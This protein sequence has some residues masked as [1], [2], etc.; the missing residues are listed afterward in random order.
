MDL[1]TRVITVLLAITTFGVTLYAEPEVTAQP[2]AEI[3]TSSPGRSR[4]NA[5]NPDISVNTLFLYRNG[6]RGNLATDANP[7]GF[8]LDEAELQFTADVDPY[9]RAVSLLAVAKDPAT[10][11]WKIEPEEAYGETLQVP[12]VTL[13]FGK[14]KAA[15]GK[16][17]TLHTHAFPFIDNQLINT[18][19]LGDEGLNDVGASASALV[20][21]NWFSEVTVQVLQAQSQPF[22]STSPNSNVVVARLKNLWD[23]NDDT[24]LEWGLSGSKGPNDLLTQTSLWG[25]D[26]TFKWRPSAGGK[27]SAI[28][29]SNEYMNG[30]KN[31]NPEGSIR[32]HGGATFIQWQFAQRWWIQ[33]R[34]EYV[35]VLDTTVGAPAIQRKYSGLLAFLPT[36]FS[37]IRLQYDQRLDGL[38]TPEQRFLVQLNLSIGAHP[39]H[40]Y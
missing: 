38:A 20:P 19:L 28:V 10:G 25:T 15:F 11:E 34:A 6:N 14:F 39:A 35:D 27:Y 4:G 24:T 33:G 23:L 12:S 32:T 7:N 21:I 22:Q 1:Y 37:A 26:L 36:E 29:W 3:S 40:A 17:N 13:R 31:L 16:Y 5:F 8:S 18:T 2:P 30:T 9:L